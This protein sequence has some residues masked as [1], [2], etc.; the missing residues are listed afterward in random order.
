[1]KPLSAKLTEQ[2]IYV[3]V[4]VIWKYVFRN[5]NLMM[6]QISPTFQEIAFSN[7]H[8]E[9]WFFLSEAIALSILMNDWQASW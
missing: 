2:F 5:K 9:K 7:Y 3:L 6:H 1:M 4:A 8:V